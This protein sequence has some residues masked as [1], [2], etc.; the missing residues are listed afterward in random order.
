MNSDKL[1]I[2]RDSIQENLHIVCW[3]QLITQ[4]NRRTFVSFGGLENEKKTN[5][6]I[7]REHNPKMNRTIEFVQSAKELCTDC[8]LIKHSSWKKRSE[9]VEKWSDKVKKLNEKTTQA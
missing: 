4:T 7:A 5:S 6:L 3:L 1:L 9:K 8:E 2:Q